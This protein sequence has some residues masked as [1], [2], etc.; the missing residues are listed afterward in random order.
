M[1]TFLGALDGVW[2][3][4]GGQ[5]DVAAHVDHVE[6]CKHQGIQEYGFGYGE[7]EWGHQSHMAVPERAIS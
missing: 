7:G 1:M 5:C 2:L 3:R 6:A 4:R